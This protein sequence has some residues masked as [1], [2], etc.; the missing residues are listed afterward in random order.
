MGR[1]K[2]VKIVQKQDAHADKTAPKLTIKEQIIKDRE[3]FNGPKKHE[4]NHGEYYNKNILYKYKDGTTC[5]VY[6]NNSSEIVTRI[7]NQ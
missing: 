7:M 4:E 5:R 2:K 1:P 3:E 6:C